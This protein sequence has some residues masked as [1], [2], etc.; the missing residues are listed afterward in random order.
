[1]CEQILA[2]NL[3]LRISL[4]IFTLINFTFTKLESCALAA[5]NI[6]NSG[7]DNYG[8]DGSHDVYSLEEPSEI[9]KLIYENR[10][11]KQQLQLY[12]RATGLHAA[13]ASELGRVT[14]LLIMAEARE[15]SLQDRVIEL[16]AS[17]KAHADSVKKR[18][19]R[20][21]SYRKNLLEARADFEL[22]NK[23]LRE[24]NRI[25]AVRSKILETQ[26]AKLRLIITKKNSTAALSSSSAK[27]DLAVRGL[28]TEI[29]GDVSVA[30]RVKFSADIDTR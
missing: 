13:R 15:K 9:E 21:Q 19:H 27:V 17:V 22:L 10:S 8:Y 16:E 24:E 3:F 7:I 11:L 2:R 4:L 26:V 29:F 5:H 23:K 12:E 18:L 14:N 28:V 25:L 30:R 6:D 20:R 1:M